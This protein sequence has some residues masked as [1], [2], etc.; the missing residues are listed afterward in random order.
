M[1]LQ[2]R[3]VRKDISVENPISTTVFYS[4]FYLWV[5]GEVS[6]SELQ[7]RFQLD[8]TEVSQAQTLRATYDGLATENAKAK[9]LQRLHATLH[10]YENRLIDKAKLASMLGLS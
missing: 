9:W 1:S 5:E 7:A 10:S 4:A 2:D 8:S 6:A 3:L